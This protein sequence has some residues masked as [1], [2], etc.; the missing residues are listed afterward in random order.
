LSCRYALGHHHLSIILIQIKLL[1]FINKGQ[2]SAMRR[3]KQQLTRQVDQ[4]DT[5]DDFYSL[6]QQSAIDGIAQ[7][8]IDNIWAPY[9]RKS[10]Q[11]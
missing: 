10:T 1:D 8:D 11:K 3:L 6:I 2:Q 5:N 9:M 7:N 4:V